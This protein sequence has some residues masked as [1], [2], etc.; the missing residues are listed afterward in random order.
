MGQ[1]EKKLNIVGENSNLINDI[2]D[3]FTDEI[4]IGLCGPIG[5]NIKLTGERIKSLLSD[6]YNYICINIKLSDFISE[7]TRNSEIKINESIFDRYNRLIKEGNTLREQYGSSILAQFAVNEITLNREIYKQKH[8]DDGYKNMRY[9]YVIDSIKNIDEYLLLKSIYG[10]IFYFI[11]IY[12][13]LSQRV[14][15]LE[16]KGLKL[17]EVY[18]LV[19]KDSG[20]EFDYGQKVSKTFIKSDYFLR[21]D[22]NS[23][24]LDK[25]LS[26]FLSLLFNSDII[27]PYNHETAMYL[28]TTA[29][30]NSACLSRQVGACIT[31]SEGEVLSIGWNDV[32]KFGSYVY[33]HNDENDDRCYLKENGICFNDR[34]KNKINDLLYQELLKSRVI[35]AVDK[36]KV[37]SVLKKSRIKELLEF[38]RAV[39]AEMLALIKAG[40]KSGDAMIGGSLYCTTYPCHNCARHIIASGIKNVYYIEPYN[41]SLAT[42]LHVDSITD[43]E[44]DTSKVRIL[45]YDGISPS[46]YLHFFKMYDN[47]RKLNGIKINRG[48]K[49]I[50]YI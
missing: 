7:H 19:D 49:I 21:L 14:L 26:R 33:S 13:S 8:E 39:H 40:H 4:I 48:V 29:S 36:D 11:G 25:K 16:E 24:N 43:N 9:C 2:G 22:V 50:T 34:E 12:S 10:D 5:T 17:E 31:D 38:S 3:T 28:A 41:K 15:L 30:S 27:T 35:S 46:R 1:V 45:M 47:K 23:K 32:P 18:K 6:N 37:M 44:T 42:S 20:E